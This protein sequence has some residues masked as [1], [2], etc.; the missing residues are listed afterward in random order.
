MPSPNPNPRLSKNDL[1]FVL[2][3]LL[4]SALISVGIKVLGPQLAIP[5]T[6]AVAL[7]IVLLPSLVLGVFLLWRGRQQ[8]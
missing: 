6:S 2:K 7:G 8:G 4:L 3:I 1:G 5:A